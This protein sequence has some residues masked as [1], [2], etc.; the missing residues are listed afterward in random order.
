MEHR[1]K[2]GNLVEH[3][4]AIDD[5]IRFGVYKAIL[6]YNLRFWLEHNKARGINIKKHTDG[7]KYYWTYNSGEAFEKLFPYMNSRSIRRWLL[8][9]E[10]DGLIISNNFNKTEYDRTKWYTIPSLYQVGN[11]ENDYPKT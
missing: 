6:L 10:N 2:N 5:A 9:M 4:F 11:T 1:N 8:E 7:K 3:H